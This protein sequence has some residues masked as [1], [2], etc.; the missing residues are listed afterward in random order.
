MEVCYFYGTLA[1]GSFKLVLVLY[2]G[3]SMEGPLREVLL[4]SVVVFDHSSCCYSEKHY[5]VPPG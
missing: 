3:L 2:Y 4:F 1:F 5:V